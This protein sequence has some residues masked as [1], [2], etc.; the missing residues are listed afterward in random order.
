MS[1]RYHRTL[2]EDK[3]CFVL[4]IVCG[5]S[6]HTLKYFHVKN[7]LHVDLSAHNI[8]ASLVCSDGIA[9]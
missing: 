3:L 8:Q 4:C 6:K 1:S 2:S 5:N 9:S 7:C